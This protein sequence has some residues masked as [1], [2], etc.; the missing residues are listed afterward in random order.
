MLSKTSISTLIALLLVVGFLVQANQCDAQ[1]FPVKINRV[2]DVIENWSKSQHLFIKGELGISDSQ[3]QKL[4]SWISQKAP[5]WTV[6]L[7]QNADREFYAAQ[8]SL[9]R[10]DIKRLARQ[11]ERYS[12][13][14]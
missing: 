10:L 11:A 9:D 2:D 7:M 8:E 3:F 1:Q 5:N 6:V 12:F 14:F 4:E 13:C